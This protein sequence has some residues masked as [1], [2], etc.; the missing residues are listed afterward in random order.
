[1]F[2]VYFGKLVKCDCFPQLKA[3]SSKSLAVILNLFWASNFTS[4]RH[5][6][7]LTQVEHIASRIRMGLSSPISQL[8][9]NASSSSNTER[10]R[11]GAIAGLRNPPPVF[12]AGPLGMCEGLS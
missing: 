7:T 8:C 5:L 6:R 12:F 3:K 2:S 9:C 1:M 10:V 4:L 11:A